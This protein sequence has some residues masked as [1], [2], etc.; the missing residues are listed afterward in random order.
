MARQPA[1]ISYTLRFENEMLVA[2]GFAMPGLFDFVSQTDPDGLPK[3]PRRTVRGIL[4]AHMERFLDGKH[5]ILK[6]VFGVGGGEECEFLFS[7]AR[8]PQEICK[9]LRDSGTLAD[10][11]EALQ[12]ERTRIAVDPATRCAEEHHLFTGRYALPVLGLEGRIVEDAKHMKHPDEERCQDLA[13]LLLALR[14][15]LEVGG[16][17][18]RG[19]GT[20]RATVAPSDECA[21]LVGVAEWGTWGRETWERVTSLVAK[22]AARE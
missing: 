5:E 4:R 16:D 18:R 17:R 11:G 3:I 1:T 14:T 7:D 6:R 22:E 15:L 2:S 8:V 19:V 10:A 9:R 13:A 12:R 21:R 20:C